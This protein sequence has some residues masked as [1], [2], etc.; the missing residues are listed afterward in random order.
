MITPKL[1]AKIFPGTTAA[2][3]DRFIDALN[4]YLPLYG[5]NTDKRV[6]AFLAT[7]GIETD[8]LKTTV[9]YA[10]GADYE[11][12]KSLGNTVPGDGKRFRGR[13]FFQTTGRYNYGRVN[14]RLGGKL[15]INFLVN[16]ARLAEID[17]AVESACIF[18]QENN[19]N[20]YADRNEFKQLSAVVNCGNPRATPNHWSK[21][22]RLYEVCQM[23][24]S[25]DFAFAPA[26]NP[27]VTTV[28][29]DS[30]YTTQQPVAPEPV[31]LTPT[32]SDGDGKTDLPTV[33]P[34]SEAEKSKV[35]EFSEKYLKH[36]PTDTVKN[37]C[38]TVAARVGATVGSTGLTV[39]EMGLP[40][41][42]I[43]IVAALSIIGFTAYAL[44]YY[45]PRIINWIKDL[46]DP[47]LPNTNE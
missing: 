19:L 36:C 44:Y 37:V 40:G 35:K 3:R 42:I 4:R 46:V 29:G 41:K 33:E 15:G 22:K 12:R 26:Q 38:G 17:V 24:V 8:Y 10:S 14:Q 27:V 47:L 45:T 7:G 32:N 34:T 21:R 16:P 20:K 5:I 25:K 9:E 31:V 1:L 28:I 39:W 2:K 11:G 23:F 43:L 18:W 13:G 30:S 6:N